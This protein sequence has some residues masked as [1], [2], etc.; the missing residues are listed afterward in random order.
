MITSFMTINMD[1]LSLTN[2]LYVLVTS[3]ILGSILSLVFVYTRKR[4]V[5]DHAF[6]F[7]LLLLPLVISIIIMLVSDN[8]ARAFS[9]AGVFALVRFRTAIADSRDITY[10]LSAVGI[11]LATAMGYLAYAVVITAFISALLIVLS[12]FRL[13][14]DHTNHAKLK[15]IIPENLNY[16]NAFEDVFKEHLISTQLQKVK[17][18]DFGTMFELTYIIKMKDT[19]DQKKFLDALRV[20]N[21][22]LSITMTTDYVSLTA[23]Q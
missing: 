15:I 23:E 4:T 13:D 19:I 2:I 12:Y 14:K 7:T 11:G 6:S 10:I 8:L 18:T 17:T 20:R 3:T 16:S 1:T 21:G 9:L 5:Y 22:N